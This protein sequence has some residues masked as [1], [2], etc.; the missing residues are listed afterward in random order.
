MALYLIS[1]TPILEQ[2]GREETIEQ[3][4][5]QQP[6]RQKK[7][8]QMFKQHK[9]NAGALC[10]VYDIG[11]TNSFMLPLLSQYAMAMKFPIYAR[12]HNRIETVTAKLYKI[13]LLLHVLVNNLC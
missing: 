5:Q 9:S 11:L 12:Q 13:P 10:L 2:C 8:N 6:N 7:S 1:T 4:Q 3:Q